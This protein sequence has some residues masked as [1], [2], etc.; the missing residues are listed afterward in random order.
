MIKLDELREFRD[1]IRYQNG[2]KIT[3][4][5]IQAALQKNALDKDI[6]V[7]FKSDQV[8]SGGLLKKS[9]E[10][11]IVLYHPEHEKDYFKFCIRVQRQGTYAFVM[12]NDF[13]E[14][15]QMKK[16]AVAEHA[17][18]DRKGQSLSYKT[19]SLIGQGLRSIGKSKSKLEQEQIYYQCIADIL[20][21]V[22]A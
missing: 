4:E 1:T 5:T 2:D 22:I 18:A 17:K 13:G 6:P 3:L 8:K 16:A 14:S 9:I 12:V 19:G 15:K 7:A 20:D 21:E 10:D 11:C